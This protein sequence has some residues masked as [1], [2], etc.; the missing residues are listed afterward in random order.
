[1]RNEVPN[2]ELLRSDRRV[3]DRT[4][5]ADGGGAMWR[6]VCDV[7]PG[8]QPRM[9]RRDFSPG[10]VEQPPRGVTGEGAPRGRSLLF[11]RDRR[12][13]AVFAAQVDDRLRFRATDDPG[14]R[15]ATAGA[16]YIARL[17][18]AHRWAPC[19]SLDAVR[20]DFGEPPNDGAPRTEWSVVA[21]KRA[22]GGAQIPSGGLAVATRAFVNAHILPA[23][24][25]AAQLNHIAS[26]GWSAPPLVPGCASVPP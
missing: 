13:A 19:I 25:A 6:G 18:L 11:W 9:W 21:V 20:Q 2:S 10:D 17:S 12:P 14:A 8:L 24:A 16:D 3:E 7:A 4:A 5:P 22:Y 15:H 26:S 1:V 23:R